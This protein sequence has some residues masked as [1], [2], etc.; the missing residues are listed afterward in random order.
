MV[1]DSL[2][3][4]ILEVCT[5]SLFVTSIRYTLPFMSVIL[6]PPKNYIPELFV[7]GGKDFS[8]KLQ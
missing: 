2:G 8:G 4:R 1:L 6:F 7:Q 3:R 5:P